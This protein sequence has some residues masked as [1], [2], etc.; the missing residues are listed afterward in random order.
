MSAEKISEALIS[1]IIPGL[2]IIIAALPI[3]ELGGNSRY[4]LAGARNSVLPGHHWKYTP[5][6]FILLLLKSLPDG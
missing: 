3:I 2:V 6:S 4:Q 1:A 5:C